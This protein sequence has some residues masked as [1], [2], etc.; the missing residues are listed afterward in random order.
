M[1]PIYISKG[2]SV[3]IP[4]GGLKISS[5]GESTA[6]LHVNFDVCPTWLELALHHLRECKVRKNERNLAWKG[7]KEFDQGETLEREFASSM[8]VIMSSAIAFD[9]FYANV[10]GKVDL[11]ED[12]RET[13]KKKRTPRYAQIAE[14]LKRDYA[15]TQDGNKILRTNLK[16]IFRFRDMA[17]HPNSELGEAM[18]HP[19][20]ECGVEWRFA[21]FRYSNAYEVLRETLRMLNFFVNV[22]K[23]KN[24]EVNKYTN[25]LKVR[26]QGVMDDFVSE[27]GSMEPVEG[28]TNA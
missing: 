6:T 28:Q 2:M 25:T 24:N 18:W 21:Y 7:S 27:F 4:A 10:K 13:W 16:E 20:L 9:A 23:I 3:C 1:G 22:E 15:L 17:I 19:E 26:T 8:Q 11:P 12:I 5:N 14:V